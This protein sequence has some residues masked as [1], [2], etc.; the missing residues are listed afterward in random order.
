MYIF[1][2]FKIHNYLVTVKILTPPLSLCAA[3]LNYRNLELEMGMPANLYSK[4]Q[5]TQ[6]TFPAFLARI[7]FS[8]VLKASI[9]PV[10]NSSG[11][12]TL[13]ATVP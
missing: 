8:K 1:F 6:L 10:V 2:I 9:Y 5:I 11:L 12:E 3:I 4:Y 7:L 13:P